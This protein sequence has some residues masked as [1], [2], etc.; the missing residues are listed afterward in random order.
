MEVLFS[1]V[2][3]P[4]DIEETVS[5]HNKRPIGQSNTHIQM[6]LIK[7]L[8][9][10]NCNVS[11]VNK[12]YVNSYP[13][14][15]SLAKISEY[16]F[17]IDGCNLT[18]GVGFLNLPVINKLSFFKYMKKSVDD[19]AKK[20]EGEERAIICYPLTVYNLD[21]VKYVKKKYPDIKTSIIV[22][23]LPRFMRMGLKKSVK[24]FVHD[25]YLSRMEKKTKKTLPYV[26]TWFLFSKH[27]A[28][29][30]NCEENYTVMEGFHRE[31]PAEEFSGEDDDILKLYYAGG[32]SV[33]YGVADLV[34]AFHMVKG[35]NLRLILCGGGDA[36]DHVREVAAIDNRIDFRGKVPYEEANRLLHEVDIVVNPRPCGKHEFTKYSFP[37]KTIE[38]LAFGKP[39]I[40]FRLEGIPEEYDDYLFYVDGVGPEGL[41]DKI[42]EVA[43]LTKRE[44]HEI[45]ERGRV[46]INENKTG[47]KQAEKILR[48]LF[49]EKS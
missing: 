48:S 28:T 49:N 2:M 19:W 32:L 40:S 25:L 10:C 31:M 11:V 13:R 38:A 16:N 46:F 45:G 8:I 43:S 41:R 18:Y 6:A 23:D 33:S 21:L 12:L 29:Y 27:M 47:R 42:V 35:D 5:K 26:D 24:K 17:N 22:P 34:D 1:S 36:A 37:S 39:L 4:L 44:L 15:Y 9:D 14:N 30:L 20:T 7:G 3:I